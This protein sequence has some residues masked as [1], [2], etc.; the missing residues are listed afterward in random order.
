MSLMYLPKLDILYKQNHKTCDLWYGLVYLF[1][2]YF[3]VLAIEPR[4]LL[5]LGKYPNH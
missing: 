1:W 4:L 3:V 2:D 5:I